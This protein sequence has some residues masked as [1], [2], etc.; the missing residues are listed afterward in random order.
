MRTRQEPRPSRYHTWAELMERVY[1]SQVLR[2]PRC[3]ST[4]RLIALVTAPFVINSI[5][6]H[7]GLTTGP[8]K[9]ALPLT[10]GQLELFEPEVLRPRLAAPA[11]CRSPPTCRT[12]AFD[13]HATS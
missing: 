5:L 2:C 7:I 13:T 6:E 3:N 10:K 8:R 4:L 1:G 9:P 11:S 12:P